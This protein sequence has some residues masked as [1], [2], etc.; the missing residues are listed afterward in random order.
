MIV[1]LHYYYNQALK[2]LLEHE[3]MI[4]PKKSMNDNNAVQNS[5]VISC[6]DDVFL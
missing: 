1:K 3:K 2:L 4:H 6:F 5:L